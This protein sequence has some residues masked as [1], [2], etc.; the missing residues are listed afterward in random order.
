MPCVYDNCAENVVSA[1]CQRIAK[2]MPEPDRVGASFAADC[3]RLFGWV[4]GA[5]TVCV[6][7]SRPDYLASRTRLVASKLEAA[8][9]DLR[10]V[11]G[12]HPTDK[13]FGKTES[14]GGKWKLKPRA[15]C[16]VSALWVDQVGNDLYTIDLAQRG[17]RYHGRWATSA[18]VADWIY[19]Q[20]VMGRFLLFVDFK[21]FDLSLSKLLLLAERDLYQWFGLDPAI[22]R[23]ISN[24]TLRWKGKCLCGTLLARFLCAGRCRQTGDIQTSMCNNHLAVFA[25]LWAYC[26]LVTHGSKCI[27]DWEAALADMDLLQCGDDSVLASR[28]AITATELN[29]ELVHLGMQVEDTDG[30]F[31]QSKM[32][33]TGTGAIMVRH[34]REFLPRF[35]VSTRRFADSRAHL[36]DV[37]VGWSYLVDGVPMYW[38][39]VKRCLDLTSGVAGDGQELESWTARNWL[40]AAGV[41]QPR[42][43]PLHPPTA[44][45]RSEFM[46]AF[47][48]SIS[49]QLE[50]EKFVS[51]M[52]MDGTIELQWLDAYLREQAEWVT[53]ESE[54]D[55]FPDDGQ[56]PTPTSQ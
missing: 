28:V 3:R 19:R 24:A 8:H 21:T 50:F 20:E 31:C 13:I 54:I 51:T 55:P 37:S 9:S 14:R 30:E 5:S 16:D 48:I 4:Y 52:P 46:W 40:L 42:A 15:I 27:E 7:V 18:K 10:Q 32:L 26:R 43:Q 47:G 23:M 34:P 1:I 17:S 36:R 41:V 2:R 56:D 25:I 53:E 11:Y 38:A 49:Q 44:R 22:I 12:Y 29:T 6:Q 33:P 45:T 35:G 39:L